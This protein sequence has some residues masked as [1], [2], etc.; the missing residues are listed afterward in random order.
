[1]IGIYKITSPTNKIYIGQSIDIK[2]R[3]NQYKN[4]QCKG[5]KALYS[6]LLKYGY[7]NHK[8]EVLIECKENELN[9]L[10]RYYQDLF[11]CVGKNGLN[12]MLT[13]TESKRRVCSEFFIKN[14]KELNKNRVWTDE[15]RLKL[16]NKQKER[17]IGNNYKTGFKH[18][19]DF[20]DKRSEIMKG[21]KNTLGFKH[22][23][24]T[25]LKMSKSSARRLLVLDF[26]TGIYHE[27][28]DELAKS[29]GIRTRSLLRKLRGYNNRK[30]NTPYRIV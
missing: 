27:S 20:K 11:N 10:E 15:S 8:I 28:I 1:M 12:L 29:L 6:S 2:K 16:G 14:L 13:E 26:N 9:E 25:K 4:L 23:D 30:N 21:N 7:D 17:M 24:E 22:S 19:Q 18:S 5:Q 3:F